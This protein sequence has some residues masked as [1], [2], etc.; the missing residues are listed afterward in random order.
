MVSEAH[1]PLEGKLFAFF[2]QSAALYGSDRVL[3]D[4]VLGIRSAGAAP[5]V[6][7]PESGPLSEVL[8]Q[9]GIEVHCVPVLKLSRAKLSALGMLS[10]AWELLS[11]TSQYDKIFSGRQ[12]DLVHSNT[13]AVLG[14]ALW[15]HRRRI[16]HVWHVHEI[17]RKPAQMG[18]VFSFLLARFT[19]RVA[20]NSVATRDWL[21]EQCPQLSDRMHVILNGI[22]FPQ[23][24]DSQMV[25]RLHSE[26]RPNGARL[27]VGLIG[28]INRMKGHG[29]LMDAVDRLSTTISQPFSVVFVGDSPSGQEEYSHQLDSRIAASPIAGSVVRCKFTKDRWPHYVALDIVCVPSIEE[30]SF[31][32]VAAEAMAMGKPV[33]ASKIGALPEVVRD[34]ATGLIVEPKNPQKLAQALDALLSDEELRQRMGEAA[35]VVAIREFS[36]LR[37]IDQFVELYAP[38]SGKR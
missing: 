33:I 6:L 36:T 18:K 17:V 5:V 23:Q 15:A 4:L 24:M 11:A 19:N 38:L 8:I 7:L 31:G 2:H 14:G 13:L 25:A 26:F 28:R 30:E 9:E 21:F 37:M 1:L 22:E 32:L 34:G 29:V 27:A 12:V 20:C 16:P 35:R 3:L 10:L